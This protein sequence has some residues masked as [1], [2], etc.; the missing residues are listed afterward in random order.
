[1]TVDYFV[2]LER[3]AE[4]K[5][6]DE[7]TMRYHRLVADGKKPDADALRAQWSKGAIN[8]S[9]PEPTEA[10]WQMIAKPDLDLTPLPPCSF[11]LR[12]TFTLAQPYISKDDNPFY[13][14]DNPIV[15]DKV[16]RLPMV[17]PTSWK[18]NLYAALW[19]LGHAKADEP[20]MK[21]LFGEIHGE[22]GGQAGRLFFYPTFFAKTC[23]EVI[24][25]HDRKR[26]VG[27]N[28]ILFESVPSG[29][30]GM[31]TLLY[32]PF[33]LVGK[34]ESATR[35]VAQDL[36]LLADG[37]QAMF[38]VYGFSAK[39]TSGFGVAQEMVADGRLTMRVIET[40]PAPKPPESPT[41]SASPL[42]KYLVAPGQ[43]KPE[44]L[45]PDDTFR[46]RSE[47]E[48][49]AMTKSDRQEY[50]KAKKWWEREGKV[51]ASQSSA[52]PG[53]AH[54]LEPQPA[55]WLTRSFETFAEL[56]ERTVEVS[57]LLET[58]GVQ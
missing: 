7:F 10:F 34:V 46:E 19:Q 18:G 49:S 50:D 38:R 15:R 53:P 48:L 31:F 4:P 25:P 55:E 16:F 27:K 9:L 52:E 41:V 11:W 29:T 37:L 22:E 33:D 43:L 32:V 3:K 54:P 56:V 58:G 35:E 17:R 57:K 44:Y 28:P 23:L 40:A 6:V 26:R 2:E 45:N 42:P 30:S 13:I 8:V 1:M 20:Q 36:R 24:N 39:R 21:R 12:F 5:N 14:I 47:T 51:L